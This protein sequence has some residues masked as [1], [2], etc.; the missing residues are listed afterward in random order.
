MKKA[1]LYILLFT[2]VANAQILEDNNN[3]TLLC[4]ENESVGF[5]WENNKWISSNFQEQSYIIQKED[6]RKCEP[7]TKRQFKANERLNIKAACYNIR[8]KEAEYKEY[9]N[10]ICYEDWIKNNG[11]YHLTFISCS[12][13]GIEPNGRFIKTNFNPSPYIV[14]NTASREDIKEPQMISHGKCIEQ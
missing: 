10:E 1:V 11:D 14:K 6:D 12:K 3:L 2:A 9:T 8:K 13:M 5:Y 7:L 4:T